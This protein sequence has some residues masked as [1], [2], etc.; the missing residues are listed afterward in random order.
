MVINERILLE[1]KRLLVYSDKTADE[2]AKELGSKEAGHFSKFFKRNE[3]ISPKEF[4]K[5]KLEGNN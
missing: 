5:L 3:K 2:I 4:R 1:A